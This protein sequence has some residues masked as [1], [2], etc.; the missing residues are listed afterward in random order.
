MLDTRQYDRDDT[1]VSVHLPLIP[2]PDTEHVFHRSAATTHVNPGAHCIK[3][4]S[5]D[6]LTDIESIAG[7]QQR[8]LM[9]PEQENWFYD[10]LSQSKERGA[11]WRLV[12]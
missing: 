6:H 2:D 5:D 1:D 9:G 10:Q 8:T 4:T 3:K 11:I 7:D 12:G